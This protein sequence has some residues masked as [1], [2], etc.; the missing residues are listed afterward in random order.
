MF[1]V[2]YLNSNINY[3]FFVGDCVSG[4]DGTVLYSVGCDDY[5]GHPI[6]Y[7]LILAGDL[8]CR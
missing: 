7:L 3:S 8:S 1:T 5:S 2:I 6:P 4:L